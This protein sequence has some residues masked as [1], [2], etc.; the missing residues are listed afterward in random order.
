MFLIR[1]NI[2][3]LYPNIIHFD[4]VDFSVCGSKEEDVSFDN[5]WVILKSNISSNFN[6]VGFI[7]SIVGEG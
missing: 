3:F 4:A 1:S 6:N 2:A 7:N 5:Q